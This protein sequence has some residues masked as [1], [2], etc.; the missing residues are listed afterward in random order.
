MS[1]FSEQFGKSPTNQNMREY[2]LNNTAG[3]FKIPPGLDDRGMGINFKPQRDVRQKY[4]FVQPFSVRIPATGVGR[5]AEGEGDGKITVNYN[6]GNIVEGVIIKG[7]TAIDEPDYLVLDNGVRIP[8]GG[9]AIQ[10]ITPY[11]VANT[12]GNTGPIIQQENYIV[13]KDFL[14][15]RYSDGDVNKGTTMQAIAPKQFLKGDRI[16]AIEQID[17]SLNKHIVAGMYDVTCCVK[18]IIEQTPAEQ[19][20]PVKKLLTPKNLIIGAVVFLAFVGLV[21]M[22]K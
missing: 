17:F 2:L 1:Q 11:F 21:R 16:S 15:G 19:T 20:K 12:P 22:V 4:I 7:N 3:G 13:T 6:V 8:F 10:I 5:A 9:R 18:P 14:A